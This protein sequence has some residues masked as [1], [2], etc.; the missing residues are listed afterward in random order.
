MFISFYST[1]SNNRFDKQNSSKSCER[2]SAPLIVAPLPHFWKPKYTNKLL[3][4]RTASEPR[5]GCVLVKA[6]LETQHTCSQ[7]VPPFTYLTRPCHVKSRPSQT[8]SDFKVA[9]KEELGQSWPAKP[10]A[11][12]VPAAQALFSFP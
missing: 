11:L 10:Q 8:S 1:V 7:P 6:K 3:K 5:R 12:N 2:F 9:P 4:K